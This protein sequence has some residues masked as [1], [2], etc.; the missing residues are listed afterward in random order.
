MRVEY[1]R[2][3]SA[4]GAVHGVDGKFEIRAAD[5]IEVREL[6]NR[7]DVGRLQIYFFDLRRAAAGHGAGAQFIFDGLH[8]R[9]RG[10][11]SKLRFELHSIPVP[12]IVARGDH[13]AAR[14]AQLLDVV[15]N[16]GRGHVV[17]GQQHGN[18]CVSDPLSGGTSSAVR[19]ETRVIA[20]NHAASGIFVLEDVAGNR[21]SH[22]A[23]VVESEIVGNEA[24]PTVGTEFDLG[25]EWIVVSR[26][27]LVV[28]NTLPERHPKRS[29]GSA[30]AND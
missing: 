18:T 12:R 30:F 29:E 14:C 16:R 20:D 17:V 4:A 3:N 22:A 13:D 2:Q 26:W 11:A 23:H 7:F 19:Q 6:G 5:Q 9:R 15:G 8:D 27:S 28:R 24:A 25:H 21:A 1:F 10:R